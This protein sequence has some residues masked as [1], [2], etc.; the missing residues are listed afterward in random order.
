M[1]NP[2][3]KF[4]FTRPRGA[5]RNDM[6]TA[7]ERRKFQ[8]TRPRGARLRDLPRRLPV[9]VVSIHAPAWGATLLIG[10]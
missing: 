8:F 6:F 9:E 10:C 7:F 4:Q 5:R 1:M 3:T 2:T